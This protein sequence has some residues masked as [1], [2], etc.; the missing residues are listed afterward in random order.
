MSNR[1]ERWDVVSSAVAALTKSGA[2]AWRTHLQKLLF[3]AE[4]WSALP[5]KPYAFVIHRFGPYAFDL[6]H[7]IADMQGFGVLQRESRYRLGASYSTS[8]DGPYTD[9]LKPL[10]DWL[11]KKTVQEL[12]VLATAEFVRNREKKSVAEEVMRLKPHV[13]R[14][15]VRKALEELD[16]EA[17]KVKA[18]LKATG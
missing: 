9:R 5:T 16:S 10:A 1:S 11:G 13:S 4:E 8:G 6:D 12:E 14:Q 17:P 2:H 18:Q 7:D 15:A 3:F